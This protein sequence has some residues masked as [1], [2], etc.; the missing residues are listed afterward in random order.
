MSFLLRVAV[1]TLLLLSPSLGHAQAGR[2]DKAKK[3]QEYLYAANGY[4]MV[5]SQYRIGKGGQLVPLSPPTVPTGNGADP[6][7]IAPNHRFAYVN[8]EQSQLMS[9]Y[10]IAEDGTLESLEPPAVPVGRRQQGQIVITP[11]SQFGYFANYDDKTISQFRIGKDGGLTPLRPALIHTD[12]RTESVFLYPNG[13]FL[14]GINDEGGISQ[15]AIRADGTLSVSAPAIQTGGI[16]DEINF[17]AEFHMAYVVIDEPK[18]VLLQY[19]V[20][21]KGTLSLASSTLLDANLSRASLTL[22][23]KNHCAYLIMRTSSSRQIRQYRIG[24]HGLLT[25]LSPPS[26]PTDSPSGIIFDPL[27]R[28]AYALNWAE[29]IK[30]GETILQYKIASN[31]G[32]VPLKPVQAAFA[33]PYGPNPR[34]L[35]IDATGRFLYGLTG[36]FVSRTTNDTIYQYKINAD[37]TLSPLSPPTLATGLGTEGLS[38]LLRPPRATD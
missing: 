27:N 32:L 19:H 11:D 13:R 4:E 30:L 9:Q 7:V 23:P 36:G 8:N 10:A 35:V 2:G 31:G 29:D 26:I 15:Y 25:A 1:I 21:S 34:D 33:D 20:G 12:H 37:G 3:P 28:Y 18:L 14:Y 38:I 22:N 6:V 24:R 16:P 5:I 17:S